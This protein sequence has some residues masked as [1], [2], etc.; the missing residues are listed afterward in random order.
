MAQNIVLGT[1]DTR[2]PADMEFRDD[3]DGECS[4]ANHNDSGYHSWSL[5]NFPSSHFDDAF[6]VEDH[7][8]EIDPSFEAGLLSGNSFR[9]SLTS[10]TAPP[11]LSR[12][13]TIQ[14]LENQHDDL[15]LEQNPQSRAQRPV[16]HMGDLYLPDSLL[17]S[18]VDTALIPGYEST[19]W[20]QHSVPHSDPKVSATHFPSEFDSNA[21][22]NIP[23]KSLEVGQIGDDLE[24]PISS[25]TGPN[26]KVIAIITTWI[27]VSPEQLPSAEDI[28]YFSSFA[29]LSPAEIN[30]IFLRIWAE[31]AVKGS[32]GPK[33]AATN[34]MKP[35]V[36]NV[37]SSRSQRVVLA[38]SDALLRAG[39][40]VSQ[41]ITICKTPTEHS[42]TAQSKRP[43]VSYPCSFC[44]RILS[45]KDAWRR[46]E[47]L[48][49]PQEGWLCNLDTIVQIGES[50]RCTHCNAEDP[51]MDHFHIEHP[52]HTR[53]GPC[54]RQPFSR[55]VFKRRDVFL[56][57]LEKVHP[58][59]PLQLHNE[60]V[61]QSHFAVPSTFDE[62][63]TICQLPESYKFRDWEDRITHLAQHFRKRAPGEPERDSRDKDGE[64][65]DE[66]DEE[67]DD[68]DPKPPRK[69]VRKSQLNWSGNT[70]DKKTFP[71]GTVSDRRVHPELFSCSLKEQ[72]ANA[73]VEWPPSSTNYFIP[74][75]TFKHLL[76]RHAVLDEL[77][78]SLSDDYLAM[79]EKRNEIVD[80]VMERARKLFAILTLIGKCKSI[81]DF[82]L[83]GISDTDLPFQLSNIKTSENLLASHNSARIYRLFTKWSNWDLQE[84]SRF[85][86]S[87]LAPVLELGH[88][89]K[90]YDLQ[91]NSILPFVKYDEGNRKT[92]GYGSVWRVKIHPEHQ[93]WNGDLE[94]EN[95]GCRQFAIKK[96]HSADKRSF[97][98]ERDALKALNLRTNSHLV[99]LLATYTFK[100]HY[101]LIFPYADGTLRSY[102]QQLK[103]PRLVPDQE[104]I[105]MW[106]AKQC[107][108]IADALCTIHE[109][110]TATD[111]TD[112]S[113][114]SSAN[115]EDRDRQ[116]GRHGDIKPENILWFKDEESGDSEATTTNGRLVIADFGLTR[117]HKEHSRSNVDPASVA[118]SPTYRPPE[119]DLRLPVSRAYDIWSLGCLYLEFITWLVYGWKG[120]E[121]FERARSGGTRDFKFYTI[122]GYKIS[123]RRSA[124]LRPSVTQWIEQLREH[125][126]STSYIKDFLTLVQYSLLVPNPKHRM[127]AK[128]VFAA[129][130][131]MLERSRSDP[132]YI[133]LRGQCHNSKN[134]DPTDDPLKRRLCI[135]EVRNPE[136][137]EQR[138]HRSI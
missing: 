15:G 24:T 39:E 72:L 79:G 8:L 28:T 126:S 18:Q 76:K 47:E 122:L 50:S 95:L 125:P 131:K 9:P 75:D 99:K 2:K 81:L 55:R 124:V 4:Q 128:D 67:D 113:P 1:G 82:M 118:G 119:C 44:G 7:D 36:P 12:Q 134:S 85:Q 6:Q 102:W 92:G 58:S 89:P 29:K 83:E 136:R 120:I 98:L 63:C 61:A 80:F 38:N 45:T 104:K 91:S 96:L 77:E 51:D 30:K 105:A 111:N 115:L 74:Q 37:P 54:C 3:E 130:S 43:R 117:F 133:S 84:L 129:L 106:V 101:H 52:E 94:T 90:H 13:S 27:E 25:A 26:S 14:S 116:Y 138:Q 53:S 31:K 57:H 32:Q 73:S 127:H 21:S 137:K 69:R 68:T 87:L 108:G 78:H 60:I 20:T 62:N 132:G 34:D 135:T 70:A 100:E 23:Q 42:V 121:N 71:P 16:N 65:K 110:K 48:R 114:E 109:Y 49:C 46:H 40:W 103:E 35:L 66:S 33:G 123:N 10:H 11:I 107:K 97:E 112:D 86:W 19:P 41:Q 93:I 88:S 59:I 22:R 17:G 64:G 5:E 56:S